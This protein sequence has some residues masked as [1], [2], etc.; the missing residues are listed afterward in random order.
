MADENPVSGKVSCQ[1]DGTIATV[2]LANPDKRNAVNAAMWGQ[3]AATMQ[4]LGAD[5]GVRCIVLRG[6]GCE[7]FAAGGDIE[8]FAALRSTPEQAEFYHGRLAGSALQAIVDCAH[9]TVALIHGACMG[10]GLEIAGQ[11]DL[12]ICGESARFGIPINK[13]GFPIYHAELNCLLALAGPAVA[14]ELL[15]EGRILGA[16]EAYAKGLVT[17]VVADAELETEAYASARRIAA[18]APLVARWHKRL[19]RRLTPQPPPLTAAEVADNLAYL[20]TEDYRIGM[21][22]FAAKRTPQFRGR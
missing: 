17:R 16:A 7:A 21:E 13:L 8:E 19:V 22:A 4:A 15:L 9:P 14:L 3:L 20:S 5:D 1:I 11:C 18:G 10:G 2:S 12:R 6:E